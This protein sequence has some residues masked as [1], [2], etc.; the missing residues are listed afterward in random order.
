M[1]IWLAKCSTDP[2]W[3]EEGYRIYHHK[4]KL[5]LSP[6]CH[7]QTYLLDPLSN[8]NV[9]EL[10]RYCDTVMHKMTNVNLK[11][12]EVRQIKEVIFKLK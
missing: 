3:G 5:I 8:H 1:A 2:K 4:P 6:W 7:P 11:P 10:G 9:T 12:G